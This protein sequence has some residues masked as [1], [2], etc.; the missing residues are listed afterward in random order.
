VV[1]GVVARLHDSKEAISLHGSCDGPRC[2]CERGVERLV[3]RV[4]LQCLP[5]DSIVASLKIPS[6][7]RICF[8]V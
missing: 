3:I 5:I 2:A 7:Q 6:P 1:R 8:E 4:S